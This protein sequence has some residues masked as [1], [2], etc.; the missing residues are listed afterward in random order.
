MW[1]EPRPAYEKLLCNN[2]LCC[3]V[4][5]LRTPSGDVVLLNHAPWHSQCI[6]QYIIPVKFRRHS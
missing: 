3:S 6:R 2:Q 5:V 4:L 1:V